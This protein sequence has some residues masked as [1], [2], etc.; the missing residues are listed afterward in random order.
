[1]SRFTARAGHFNLL[2][3]L[4][5]TWVLSDGDTIRIDDEIDIPTREG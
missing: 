5:N 2:G 1:M 4:Q 3:Q